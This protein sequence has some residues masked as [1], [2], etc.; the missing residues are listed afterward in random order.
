MT[1]GREP[2]CSEAVLAQGLF[3]TSNSLNA[4]YAESPQ[5]PFRVAGDVTTVTVPEGINCTS[6]DTWA[7]TAAAAQAQGYDVG[8]YDFRAYILPQGVCGWAGNVDIRDKR[9]QST[10]CEFPKILAHEMGHAIGTYHAGTPG[11]ECGD[12]SCV[13]GSGAKP[14][15]QYNAPHRV[16]LH[17]TDATTINQNGTYTVIATELDNHAILRFSKDANTHYYLSYREP[18]GVDVNLSA[19]YLNSVSIH[20]FS[21]NPG[22]GVAS[23][24]FLSWTLQPVA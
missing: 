16:G 13:M 1:G 11:S 12:D 7:S 20:A 6:R 5:G 23:S 4:A 9:L 18:I 14:I 2:S 17:W 24:G 19:D 8:S 10:R 15:V 3:G 22:P 21:R